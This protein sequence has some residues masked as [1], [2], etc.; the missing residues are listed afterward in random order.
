MKDYARSFYH[1][2]AWK[3]TQK[4]Y[5]QSKNYICERC[6]GVAEI[7]HHKKYITP[8]NINNPNITLNWS[9]LEALCRTCHQH[10]H[11]QEKKVVADGLKFDDKGQ[12]VKE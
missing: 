10:E 11:F 7:V 1:S 3:R 8:Q 9:N 6:G 12:L 2:S 4:A 5:M